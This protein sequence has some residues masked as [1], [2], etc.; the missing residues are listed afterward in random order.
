MSALRV[1]AET[2]KF[3][4][5]SKMAAAL[6]DKTASGKTLA[7]ASLKTK[8]YKENAEFKA[9]VDAILKPSPK[10]VEKA[11]SE[12]PKNTGGKDNEFNR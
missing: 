9:A 6:A 11:T 4:K 8:P 2:L 5:G 10:K 3:S 7:E 12:K 1:L